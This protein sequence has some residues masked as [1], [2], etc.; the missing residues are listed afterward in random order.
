M[1]PSSRKR[2]ISGLISYALALV[3]LIAAVYV[4]T[5]VPIPRQ[6]G[7]IFRQEIYILPFVVILV[8][9]TFSIQ[10][11]F[12]KRIGY[13]F[14]IAFFFIPFS[15]LLNSGTSDQYILGGTIPWRS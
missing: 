6:F 8:M 14:L 7:L 5:V 4:L 12:L 15:G 3:G 1:N 11:P 13:A 10:S 2:I 9:F